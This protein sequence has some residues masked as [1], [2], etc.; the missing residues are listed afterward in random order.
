MVG[1]GVGASVG[2]GDTGTALEI[3]LLHPAR[4]NNAIEKQRS[5]IIFFMIKSEIID[6]A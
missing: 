5:V 4:M 6:V 1:V 2:V 3:G